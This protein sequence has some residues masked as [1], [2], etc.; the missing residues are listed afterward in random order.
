MG[1]T[2]VVQLLGNEV[3]FTVT[4]VRWTYYKQINY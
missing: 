1:I 4:S 2:K 3:H